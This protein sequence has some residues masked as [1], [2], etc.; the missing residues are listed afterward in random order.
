MGCEGGKRVGKRV[1]FQSTLL[2]WQLEGGGKGGER[3]LTMG[4]GGRIR[5]KWIRAKQQSLF[6][7]E[8]SSGD[9][10]PLQPFK[11]FQCTYRLVA[12]G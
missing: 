10:I 5:W 2:V 6:F 3:M 1:F 8:A 12:V 9:T 11:L 4:G 7:V